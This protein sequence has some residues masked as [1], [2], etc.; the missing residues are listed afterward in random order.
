MQP[1]ITCTLL[2]AALI[3]WNMAPRRYCFTLNNYDAADEARLAELAAGDRVKYLVYGRERGDSG[4]PHLQGFVIFNSSVVFNTAKS[5][6]GDRCHLEPA[7]GTSLQAA[8]YCKKDGDFV[9]FGDAPTQQGK[10]SDWD[11]FKD[12]VVELGRV[13]SSRE[14]VLAYPSLW[15]RYKRAC[16]E[17][18]EALIAPPV[19]TDSQPR[20]GFQADVARYLEADPVPREI[21]FVVDPAG[22]SGKSWL[23]QYALSRW[24]DKVQVMRI[25][26]RDDMAHVVDVHKSIFMIDVPRGQM[27]YLQYSVLESLKDRMVFSPKYDSCLKILHSLPTVVCF[28]NEDPDMNALTADRYKIINV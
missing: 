2:L 16:V 12:F 22:D 21:M 23:C 11:A 24:P 3:I 17:Y 5:L 7:H 27:I 13:P 1:S 10:R 28:S 9:E 8:D 26:R 25:G 15:A 6:L 4:T 18:A 14:I 20:P 19:L